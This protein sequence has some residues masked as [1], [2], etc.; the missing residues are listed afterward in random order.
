MGHKGVS[1]RKPPKQK[2]KPASKDNAGIGVSSIG[3]ATRSQLVKPPDA[4]KA[5]IP[6][7][8]GSVKHSSDTRKNPKKR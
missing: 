5:I 7:T 1:I 8:R 2:V 3:Q 4:D 6:A